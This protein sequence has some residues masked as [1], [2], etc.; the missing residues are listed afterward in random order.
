MII[1]GF[2]EESPPPRLC[3]G[4]WPHQELAGAATRHRS[5][6]SDVLAVDVLP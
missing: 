3:R 4:L 2:K 6:P 1:S 5:F